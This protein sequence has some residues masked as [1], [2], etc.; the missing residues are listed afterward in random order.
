MPPLCCHCPSTHDEMMA[1]CQSPHW[2]EAAGPAGAPAAC[3]TAPVRQIRPVHVAWGLQDSAPTPL[4]HAAVLVLTGSC[5]RQW[6]F[7]L[8]PWKF[9]L[10]WS[11]SWVSRW[12]CV[13]PP[14][15]IA[16]YP[17]GPAAERAFATPKEG[18]YLL[19]ATLAAPSA[20]N[21]PSSAVTTEVME[22]LSCEGLCL[23]PLILARA[24]GPSPGSACSG[25]SVLCQCSE[26]LVSIQKHKTKYKH[27]GKHR[28]PRSPAPVRVPRIPPE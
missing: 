12:D 16:L 9:L 17:S 4:Q 20:P 14:S 3:G 22:T 27:G 28:L 18:R 15:P 5:S 1:R 10:P 8:P 11:S 24:F 25:Y 13:L 21:R 6:C 26:R 2:P 7:H 23:L 19:T